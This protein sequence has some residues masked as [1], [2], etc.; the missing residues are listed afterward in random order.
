MKT[1]LCDEDMLK[2]LQTAANTE[3]TSGSHSSGDASEGFGSI[4]RGVDTE[5]LSVPG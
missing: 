3:L 2:N 4:R 1:T 5:D